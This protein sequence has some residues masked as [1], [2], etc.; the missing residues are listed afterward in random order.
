MAEIVK[1]FIVKVPRKDLYAHLRSN[2]L[3]IKMGQLT[4]DISVMGI[5]PR[6][7]VIVEDVP[8][9]RIVHEMRQAGVKATYELNLEED[10]SSTEYFDVG[11]DND[12]DLNIWRD[13][14]SI[15]LSILDNNGNVGI[16]KTNPTEELDVNGDVKASGSLKVDGLS[17]DS[18]IKSYLGIFGT[19]DP[20]SM[21]HLHH[22][23]NSG[24]SIKL[25]NGTT[26]SAISDGFDISQNGSSVSIRNRENT[27]IYF[28]TN[29]TIRMYIDA[30]GYVGIGDT[31]P[32]Y[33]LEL[34]N[35]ASA[36]G[37]GRANRWDTYSSGRWKTNIRPI[38]DA[39]QKVQR[40]RGVYFDWKQDGKHDIGLIAEEVAEVV[41]E[42]VG[43][44]ANGKDVAALS[45]GRLVSL[46]IEAV[47]GQQRKIDEL[48]ETVAANQVLATRVEALEQTVRQL[49]L[50]VEKEVSK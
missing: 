48:Q 23:T 26:G 6:P 46:L 49:R 39:L 13:D 7:T 42:V 12:G 3:D 43:Y 4:S 15:A 32:Q 30:G 28:Y 2:E 50:T 1:Q 45:Y 10:G 38:P 44:E 9:S 11:V 14:G 35:T 34:P 24:L 25:T 31:S 27:P 16:G 20:K 36:A 21:L 18:Y 37:R 29:D 40:L 41:P 8:E 5:K 17:G 19:A 33:R 47:K 22:P